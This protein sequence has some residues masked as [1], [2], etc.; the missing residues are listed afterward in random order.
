MT[1]ESLS[2]KVRDDHDADI[3]F[4]AGTISRPIDDFL[5]DECAAKKERKNLILM[6]S[7]YG[8]DA[9]AAY[10]IARSIRKTY[11]D[12]EIIA[13]VD[14]ICASAGT[15]L[16]LAA[17]KLLLSDHAELGPLDAQILRSDEIGARTSGLIPLHALEYLESTAIDMFRN[18]FTQ[19][20]FGGTFPTA[21]SVKIA[22]EMT[23]GM[24]GRLYE[25][26]DPLRVAEVNRQIT[27][28]HDYGKRIQRKLKPGALERL[29]H[30]YPSHDF[31]I[32]ALEAADLFQNVD[33]PSDSLKQ[34]GAL[35]KSDIELYLQA[36]EPV[37]A[38]LHFPIAADVG[39]APSDAADP[40]STPPIAADHDSTLP[41]HH[42]KSPENADPDKTRI[43]PPRPEITASDSPTCEQDA[44]GS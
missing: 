38:F 9:N 2:E 6:I 5:I 43:R 16:I 30:G 22:T 8:G 10:R 42:E 18:Y 12:G 19:F 32:D 14:S 24:M 21:T 13:F 29:L 1:L 41:T 36:P 35:L 37:A 27:I 26:I 25:Q 4:Y 20:R 11:G 33:V 17:D 34:L 7:T 3:L 31:T 15:L 44:G 40:G 28:A 39:S 23:T